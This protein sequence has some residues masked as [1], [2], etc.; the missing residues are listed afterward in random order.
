[1][2][3][4]SPGS[5][6]HDVGTEPNLHQRLDMLPCQHQRLLWIYDPI[7]KRLPENE[8]TRRGKAKTSTILTAN[9]KESQRI[10]S[11]VSCET[12]FKYSN[13]EAE[14]ELG[15]VVEDEDRTNPEKPIKFQDIYLEPGYYVLVEYAGTDKKRQYIGL[16]TEAKYDVGDIEVTFL[17]KSAKHLMSCCFVILYAI[18]RRLI[19]LTSHQLWGFY[20]IQRAPTEQL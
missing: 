3:Y 19:M 20:L 1:M 6:A 8:K 17:R 9:Q 10:S 18:L 12:H 7:L 4:E 2:P 5:E 11:W 16:I 15:E 13:A 14:S